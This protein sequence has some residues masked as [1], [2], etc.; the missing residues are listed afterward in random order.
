MPALFS[1]RE[2][3]IAS[4]K[5]GAEGAG[6]CIAQEEKIPRRAEDSVYDGIVARL[7]LKPNARGV[8]MFADEDETR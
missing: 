1:R 2:Q 7:L 3:G 5:Q 8:V 6:L 4:F